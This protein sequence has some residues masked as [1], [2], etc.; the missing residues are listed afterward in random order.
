MLEN[1]T[2]VSDVE[3]I[4]AQMGGLSASAKPYNVKINFTINYNS[5]IKL[6]TEIKKCRR[7]LVT[8]LLHPLVVFGC[9][10][11]LYFSVMSFLL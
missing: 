6:M 4:Y 3:Q 2:A 9:L 10:C 8:L 7:S 1:D 11:I 5:H